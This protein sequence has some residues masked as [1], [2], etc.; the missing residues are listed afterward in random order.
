LKRQFTADAP[1]RLWVADITYVRTWQGFAYV[2]FVTRRLLT[3]DHR[4]ERRLDPASRH[5][6]AAGP[7]HGPCNVGGDLTGLIRHADHG[8]NYL[9]MI[10]TGWIAELRAEPSAGTVS[11]SNDNAPRRPTGSTRPS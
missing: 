6:A 1:R 2:A 3:A 5:L 10:Y 7:G 11:D 9:S 4:L 8:S